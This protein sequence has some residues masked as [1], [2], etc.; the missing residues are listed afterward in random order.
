VVHHLADQQSSA[1][2]LQ[3]SFPSRNMSIAIP[4]SSTPQP[5]HRAALV[6]RLSLL[7][8]RD[9]GE[10]PHAPKTARALDAWL[11]APASPERSVL[12]DRISHRGRGQMPPL[13]TSVVDRDG[14]ELIRD[15]IRRIDGSRSRESG[16]R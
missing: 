8:K 10:N 16:S 3:I 7:T 9:G 13:A 2:R 12:L 14:V 5:Y 4:A 1:D 11:I 15:W 6:C